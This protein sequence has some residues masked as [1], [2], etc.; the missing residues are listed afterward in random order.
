[1]EAIMIYRSTHNVSLA[2]SKQMVDEMEAK[3]GL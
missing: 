3:L 2:K 1:M